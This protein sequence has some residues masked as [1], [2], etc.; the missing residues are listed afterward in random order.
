MEDR[1]TK[2]TKGNQKIKRKNKRTGKSENSFRNLCTT[3]NVLTFASQG[4]QKERRERK[5]KKSYLKK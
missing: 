4:S 3:S 2:Q 5:G 1:S